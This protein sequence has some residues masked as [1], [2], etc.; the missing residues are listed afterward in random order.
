MNKFNV[1]KQDRGICILRV[2][3]VYF[4]KYVFVI[5]C[6]IFVEIVRGMLIN[7]LF[8]YEVSIINQLESKSY[9]IF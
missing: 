5:V 9:V 7:Y 8:D 6:F 2:Y 4:R 3:I 1:F